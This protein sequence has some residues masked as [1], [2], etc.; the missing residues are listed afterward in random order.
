[1]RDAPGFSLPPTLSA[2]RRWVQAAVVVGGVA[3]LCLSRLLFAQ[4]RPSPAGPAA[5]QRYVHPAQVSAARAAALRQ[6]LLAQPDAE[7]AAQLMAQKDAAATA[8][9]GGR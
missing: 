1:M 8:A 7:V 5:Q 4:P 6:H 2:S 9:R 3:A